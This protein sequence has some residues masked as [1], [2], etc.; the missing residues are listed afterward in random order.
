MQPYFLPYIGYFQLLSSVDKFVV[1]DDVNFINRGWINRNR[2][3]LNGK[4]H[5]FTVPLRRA[6]QNKRI[7]DLDIVAD[8]DWSEKLMRTIQQAYLK[9]PYY[10]EVLSTVEDIVYFDTLKL[11]EYLLHSITSIARLLPIE[12]EI[13]PTSRVYANAT[14]H[15]Q[16]RILDICRRE[17]ALVYINPIGGT[18]LYDR[19]RFSRAGIEL[20]FLR[21]MQTSYRQSSNEHLPFL[22]TLDVLMHNGVEGTRKLLKAFHYE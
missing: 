19:N 1:F 12:T 16:D 15:G 5:L 4:A 9:A 13:V 22:S 3:L 17:S 6:S 18:E 20:K 10:L 2:I 14:L 7:C 11:D 8:S 21:P